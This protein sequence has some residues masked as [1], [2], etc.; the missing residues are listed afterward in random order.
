MKEMEKKKKTK[1]YTK[2]KKNI[3][4]KYKKTC[5]VKQHLRMNSIA[6]IQKH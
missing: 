4:A 3:F 5:P 2:G 1:P 6:E